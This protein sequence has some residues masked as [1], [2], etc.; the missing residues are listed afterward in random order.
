MAEALDAVPA[1]G[2]LKF[3]VGS[4]SVNDEVTIS[5][6][7]TIL[8]N[9]VI[10]SKGLVV[11]DAEVVVDNVALNVTGADT[12]DKATALKVSGT[13]PFTLK[14]S[15]VSGTTRT[16]VSILTS[17]EVT[18]EDNTFSAGSQNIYNMVEFSIGNARDISK[19]TFTD[20]VFNGT[21]KN[22]AVSFYNLVDG[23]EI[24]FV[25][26]AFDSFD[27]A[28]NPIRLSNPR[29]VNA[30]FNFKNN[31]YSFN[32]ETPDSRGYTAFMLL[33]DYSKSDGQ[34]F[35]KFTINFDNL[36]RGSKKLT[37]K[38]SGIDNVFY[39]YADGKGILD[40]GINDPVVSFK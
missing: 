18:F 9:G 15:S 10:F 23:A 4:A 21:L 31:T 35:S 11:T 17:G 1:G 12:S 27:V 25:G 37:E 7:M 38:G 22:N 32:S 40:D 34:D 2:T 6:D 13:K 33:Q 8:G 20:N 3:P 29:N 28:N 5:K 39:V 24:D 14:N 30:V 16:A 26:N 19:V 36:V